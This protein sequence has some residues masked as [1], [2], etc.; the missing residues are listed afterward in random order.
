M[1]SNICNSAVHMTSLTLLVYSVYYPTLSGGGFLATFAP[2]QV[3]VAS[4]EALTDAGPA[5]HCRRSEG[6]VRHGSCRHG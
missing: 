5:V 3:P 4:A 2:S 1:I 6:A